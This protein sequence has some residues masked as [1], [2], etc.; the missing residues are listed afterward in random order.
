[1]IADEST[2]VWCPNRRLDLAPAYQRRQPRFEP[3]RLARGRPY[4][5][6]LAGSSP[7]PAIA[8]ATPLSI[9]AK[10]ARWMG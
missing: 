8:L 4:P 5:P 9:R 3:R 10:T 1:M 7:A 2:Q 6:G